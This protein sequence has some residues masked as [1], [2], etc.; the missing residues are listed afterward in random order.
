[1]EGGSSPCRSQRLSNL[2]KLQ[3]FPNPV[4]S[5]NKPGS[6]RVRL[7][8]RAARTSRIQLVTSAHCP[9]RRSISCV[10]RPSAL[11]S[12]PASSHPRVSRPPAPRR[13]ARA[14]PPSVPA[15]AGS[16]WLSIPARGLSSP[17][18][19]SAAC[20]AAPTAA[21]AGSGPG[22]G[23]ETGESG[24]SPWALPGRSTPSTNPVRASRSS[25]ASTTAAPGRCWEPCPDPRAPPFCQGA[26]PRGRAG[27]SLFRRVP[28]PV[29]ER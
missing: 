9:R 5:S 23:S 7:L 15:T 10:V 16:S 28:G 14:S 2:F 19:S 26:R 8:V 6:N 25:A 12:C 29:E 11:S 3:I 1:M 20:S 22:R 13:P 21:G 4:N 18:S 17:A 27:H 24:W